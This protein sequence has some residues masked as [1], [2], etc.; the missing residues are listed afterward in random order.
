M[1]VQ[2]VIVCSLYL[3]QPLGLHD[4]AL[5]PVGLRQVETWSLSSACVTSHQD[6]Q[7]RDHATTAAAA[8]TLWSISSLGEYGRVTG[9]IEP[10][11]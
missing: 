8:A 3:G 11:A 7:H 2:G 6:E 5:L 9:R 1:L 10:A 4:I